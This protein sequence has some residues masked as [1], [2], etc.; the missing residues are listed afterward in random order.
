MYESVAKLPC[1]EVTV[2]KLPCGEV[3]GNRVGYSTMD[4]HSMPRRAGVLYA[5][6]SFDFFT[7]HYT[8]VAVAIL[9]IMIFRLFR[10]SFSYNSAVIQDRKIEN[11]KDTGSGM[12]PVPVI[13][14]LKWIKLRDRNISL[15]GLFYYFVML[16]YNRGKHGKIY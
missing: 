9:L 10:P 2:A 5:F 6:L 12:V 1:G 3:T 14:C 8:E 16:W 11:R 13:F 4:C 15:F 7:V